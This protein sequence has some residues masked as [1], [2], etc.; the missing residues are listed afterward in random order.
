VGNETVQGFSKNTALFP[1]NTNPYLWDWLGKLQGMESRTPT[2]KD[3]DIL[4]TQQV[5]EGGEG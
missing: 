1:R 4:Y 3:M 5:T 2:S